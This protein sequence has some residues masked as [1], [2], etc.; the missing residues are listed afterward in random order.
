MSEQIARLREHQI[1][2]VS[3]VEG[4]L[5]LI[6][7]HLTIDPNSDLDWWEVEE[8]VNEEVN[9][10]HRIK[11]RATGQSMSGAATT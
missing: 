1:E 7:T 8:I 3:A 11:N 5:E 4:L 6:A 9:R 2:L 10:A